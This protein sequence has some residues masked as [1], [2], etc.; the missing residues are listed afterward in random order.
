M[1]L[2]C[3]TF[4]FNPETA[5]ESKAE[6]CRRAGAQKWEDLE[7]HGEQKKAMLQKFEAELGELAKLY[8]KTDEGPFL[9]GETPMYAD[10]IVGGWLKF[11]AESLP[12]W[13]M[14]QE[15]QGGHWGRLHKALGKYAKSD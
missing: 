13:H 6:F 11:Y 15:W 1:A 10:L 7:V 9:E 12:E 14:V 4:L 8:L 3:Q 5:E 2:V